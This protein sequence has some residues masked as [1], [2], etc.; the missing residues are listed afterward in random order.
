MRLSRVLLALL[1]LPSLVQ[2][3]AIRICQHDPSRYAYRM[4]LANLILQR[5]AVTYGNAEL[6]PTGAEDPPQERCLLRL[7]EGEVDLAYVPPSLD[8]LRD[9][10]ML[11]MDIQAGIQG[12]RLLLIRREDAPGFAAIRNLDDLRVMRAGFVNQWSDYAIFARNHMLVTPTSR[13]E[14]LLPML[15]EQR[16]DYSHRA[17]HETWAEMDAQAAQYPDVMVEPTLMLMYRL[18]VYFTFKRGNTMLRKRF[19]EGLRMVQADGSFQALFMRHFGD[20]L[21]RSNLKGR[22]V[23]LLESTLPEG[24]PDPDNRFWW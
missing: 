21:R 3:D 13:P 6:L 7:R 4:E 11:P 16:F 14:N 1:A 8:R 19:E 22:R 24:L 17:L 2:A 20:A 15:E 9:F 18:P 5:T 10:D 23:L 12:F